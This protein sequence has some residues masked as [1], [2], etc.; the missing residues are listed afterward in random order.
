VKK[1]NTDHEKLSA[2]LD[3]EL[4]LSEKN[5]LEEMLSLSSELREKLAELQKIKEITSSSY[6]KLA[7]SPYLE[8][9]IMAN[10]KHEKSPFIRSKWVPVMGMVLLT[11]VVMAVLKFNPGIVNRIVQEQTTNIAAF[12]KE[13]LKPLLYASSLSNEDIFNFAFYKELPLDNKK[14]QYLQI[15]QNEKGQEYFEIKSSSYNTEENNYE[16]FIT[17][18]SLNAKQREGVDSILQHYAAEL[19]SQVLVNDRNTVAVN[20]NLWNY[21]TAI[22]AD[23]VKFASRVNEPELR[24]IVPAADSY[25]RKA[26]MDKVIYEIKANKDNNYIFLTPDTIFTSWV[27]VDSKEI[28]SELVKA[29]EEIRRANREMNKTLSEQQKEMR[30]VFVAVNL[31]SLKLKRERRYKKEDFNVSFRDNNFRIVIPD[32]QIPEISV[33][34]MDSISSEID[35]ILKSVHVYTST[36]PKNPSKLS[37]RYNFQYGFKDSLKQ[38]VVPQITDIDSLMNR[39]FNYYFENNKNMDSVL[40]RFMPEF[41][42]RQ[43]SLTN[44][45]KLYRDTSIYLYESEL[46]NQLKEIEVEMRRFREEMQH[47]RRELNR[48][49]SRNHDSRTIVKPIEI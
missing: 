12:Y 35:Q 39:S 9:R 28:Q 30:R 2:Y 10:L 16:K 14:G 25:F 20:P 7:E 11:A 24:K 33:P 32:I 46:Q 27:D 19:Q 15:G 17:A 31:D 18:L 34:N 8:T 1:S 26:D 4:P 45:F 47:L 37:T 40:S 13:N 36:S 41:K 44:Y 5:E 6:K 23:L 43:D 21:N 48:D 29:R 22:A 3:G 38:L 49:S 42:I